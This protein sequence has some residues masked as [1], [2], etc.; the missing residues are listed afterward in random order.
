M[1]IGPAP[2]TSVRSPDDLRPFYGMRADGKELD[3]GGIAERELPA[4]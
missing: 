4:G 1:P 3:H 2:T